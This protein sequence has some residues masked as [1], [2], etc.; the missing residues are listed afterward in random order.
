MAGRSA[1]WATRLHAAC[2]TVAWCCALNAMWLGL[3]LLGGVLLGIGPATVTACILSRR[4]M[5]GEAVRPRE[6]WHTWRREFRRGTAVVLPAVLAIGLLLTNEA[7]FAARGATAPRVLTLL[8]LVPVAAGSVYLAPMYAHYEL[9]LRAYP[10]KALRFALARPASTVMLLFVAASLAFASAAMPVLV[11]T[12]SIGAWLYASTWLCVR[13]FQENED[14]L[15]DRTPRQ[16]ARNLPT[17]PL[18]IR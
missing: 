7:Y 6:F 12:V 14:R 9:P 8:A 3:S 5:R 11:G 10:G 16:P 1:S 4:R 2:G 13:F 15:A 17:E 18:R